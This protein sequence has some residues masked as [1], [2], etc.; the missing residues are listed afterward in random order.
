MISMN[1]NRKKP[2]TVLIFAISFLLFAHNVAAFSVEDFVDLIADFFSGITGY[3]VSGC[4]YN[5]E[6]CDSYPGMKVICRSG[7]CDPCIGYGC[8]QCPS[9]ATTVSATTTPVA[10]TQA[11][12]TTTIP[13]VTTAPSPSCVNS[14]GYC[15]EHQWCGG[16]CSYSYDC[17]SAECCCFTPATTVSV[18]T[19]QAATT[20]PTIT[21][22]TSTSTSTTTTI[23][24]NLPDLIIEEIWPEGNRIYY[25]IAN[26]GNYVASHNYPGLYVDG[27]YKGQNFVVSPA[28][29][30]FTNKYFEFYTWVCS[31]TSDTIKVCADDFASRIIESD[32]D[33][34]CREEVWACPSTTT[35]TTTSTTTTTTILI[36]C[37]QLDSACSETKENICTIAKG[38]WYSNKQCC[39]DGTCMTTCLITTTTTTP[40]TTTA[41]VTTTT[42]TSTTTTTIPPLADLVIEDIW[43]EENKIHYKITNQGDKGSS[44]NY[45]GLYV[46]GPYKGQVYGSPITAGSF[47]NE[48]FAFYTW[49]C[50]GTSDT[51]KVC[52]DEFNP[53]V[54]ESNENNNC[55]TE[56]WSCPGFTATTTTITTTVPE[57]TTT[58]PVLDTTT[59]TVGIRAPD[60]T[61]PQVSITHEPE[62]PGETG[63]FTIT[64]TA[65]DT[66]SGVKSITIYKKMSG[67]SWRRSKTGVNPS[68]PETEELIKE[69]VC[70]PGEVISYYAVASDAVGNMDYDGDRF[71]PKSVTCS[72]QEET[73]PEGGTSGARQPAVISMSDAAINLEIV[74]I[75]LAKLRSSAVV[76]KN[77][78][79]DEN[80]LEKTDR[81]A[82]V[83]ETFDDVLSD[84]DDTK[85]YLKR[86]SGSPT[87]SVLNVAES[88]VDMALSGIDNLNSRIMEAI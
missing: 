12:T 26:Q 28:P 59:T 42:T 67:G 35:T 9:V 30:S 58:T 88:K 40:V 54:T 71:N 60:T 36:G 32:E 72:E 52:A 41:P 77:Y 56:V 78:Y 86:N 83:V 84:L 21:T 55:R 24:S 57:T 39:P 8:Y 4:T 13:S 14:G 3:V 23:I 63:K 33:N 81:W 7:E 75:K 25:K 44:Y 22:T 64:A 80:E 1:I 66:G 48:Y 19:T 20:R 62:Y 11:T 46:D 76:I 27:P 51:I 79:T 6:C 43:P 68:T 16:P 18:A 74:S 53:R 17:I 29:G 45:P 37:C 69:L 15:E 82:A 31:D 50:S 10:T 65:T 38:T 2:L 61:P 87:E 5:S 73:T 47:Q 34:N 85:D 70:Q 49:S